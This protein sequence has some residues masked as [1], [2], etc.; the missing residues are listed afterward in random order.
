MTGA[1]KQVFVDVFFPSLSQTPVT[2]VIGSLGDGNSLLPQLCTINTF[3]PP[4]PVDLSPGPTRRR[5]RPFCHSTGTTV[6]ACPWLPWSGKEVL[7]PLQ[8]P[9][10]W[11]DAC[12]TRNWHLPSSLTLKMGHLKSTVSSPTLSHRCVIV[13]LPIHCAISTSMWGIY[14]WANIVSL[15]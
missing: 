7:C 15:I 13:N 8:S 10:L 4:V 1:P 5:Y 6:D 9:E 2:D 12:R 11:Y 3:W 14:Y